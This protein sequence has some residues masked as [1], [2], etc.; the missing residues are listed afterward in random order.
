M[1]VEQVVRSAAEKAASKARA[2]AKKQKPSTAKR[3]L[4][5]PK[6][7]KNTPQ[8]DGTRSPELCRITAMLDTLLHLIAG[9]IPLTYLV[10]DGSI[11]LKRDTP[12]HQ[13][14][15]AMA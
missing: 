6:G 7:S 11:H 1:R 14:L 10:L 9:L 4:G 13:A 15:S 3:R 2:D 12:G 8:A 5:R